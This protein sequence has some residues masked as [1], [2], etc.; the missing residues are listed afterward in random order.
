M[1]LCKLSSSSNIGDLF[2]YLTCLLGKYVM[3][4]LVSLAVI[5][6]VWGVIQ[7]FLFQEN[8]EKRKKG[9]EFIVWGLIA[10]F[11]I[12]SVWGLVGVLTA[13]F[14]LDKAIPQLSQ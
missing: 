10:L 4:L 1:N 7:F 6:F 5:G 8:E 2:S 13:T 12:V 3:P 14:G 11:V 9:K